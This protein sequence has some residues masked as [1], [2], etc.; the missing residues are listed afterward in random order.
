MGEAERPGVQELPVR[1]GVALLAVDRVA[2]HGM[3]DRLHVH[4]DLMGPAGFE[5]ALHV[6]RVGEPFEHLEARHGRFSLG[7]DRHL[8]AVADVA[9]DRRVD[10]AEVV[11]DHAFDD[12]DVLALRLLVLELGG[13]GVVGE[14]VLRDHQ[15]PGGVLVDAVDDP[16][17]ER[18]ADPGK[19]LEMMEQR[20]HERPGVVAGGG[21]DDHP[22][23][24]VDDDD[25]L[26]LV[27]DRE[28]DVFGG[29]VDL[30]DRDLDD[31]DRVAGG[32]DVGRLL[33]IAV[34]DE[35]AVLDQPLDQ[36]A[37]I[38][39]EDGRDE[40]VEADGGVG[41]QGDILKPLVELTRHRRS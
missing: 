39:R 1:V 16:G 17:A 22:G 40:L 30:G 24:L 27:D 12:R 23:G 38:L 20:V 19:V 4:A 26:I 34:D 6:G 35:V 21:M 2:R 36:R 18:S 33:R 7:R 29:R 8:L 3:A 9:A 41:V 25:V 28:R 13:K 31:L 32:D 37:R 14:V 11:L 5:H 10:R 15:E